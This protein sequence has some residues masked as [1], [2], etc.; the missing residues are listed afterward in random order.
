MSTRMQLLVTAVVAVLAGPASVAAPAQAAYEFNLPTQSL[1]D[2]LRAI[3]RQSALNILFEP[4]VV[5]H[6]VAPPVKGYLSPAEAIQRVLN[7]TQLVVQEAAANSLVIAPARAVKGSESPAA[8]Q[9]S[10]SERFEDA[11]HLL[12]LAQAAPAANSAR[13]DVSSAQTD[14]SEERVGEVLVK[15]TRFYRASDSSMAAKID[16]PILETPQAVSVISNDLIKTFGI[17]DLKWISRYV[18]GLDSRVT[19]VAENSDFTARGFTLDLEDGFKMNGFQY[20]PVQPIDTVA[21]ERIEFLKGPTGILYGRNDYGGMLNYVT[22]QPENRDF[23][24]LTFSAGGGDVDLARAE[25]DTN[26]SLVDNVLMLRVPMAYELHDT[27]SDHHSRQFSAVPSLRWQ[28]S[29]DFGVTLATVLQRWRVNRQIGLSPWAIG[30]SAQEVNW[31]DGNGLRCRDPGI[32]CTTPPSYLRNTFLGSDVDFYDSTM[33]QV[34][35]KADYRINDHLNYFLSGSYLRS[36]VQTQQHY[37]GTM[38]AED[39]SAFLSRDAIDFR[40]RS[41]GV[42][43]GVTGDFGLF[44]RRHKF[45]VGGDYRRYSL[46]EYNNNDETL[47]AEPIDVFAFHDRSDFKDYLDA[48]GLGRDYV[49]YQI[50]LDRQRR[51]WG[52]GAQIVFELADPLTLLV[53]GRY[54]RSRFDDHYFELESGCFRISCVRVGNYDGDSDERARGSI[55]L[56]RA[57]LTWKIVPDRW[58][59]YASY[60]KGFI[61]QSGI[62]RSGGRIGPETGYQIELGV[63]GQLFEDRF[64]ASFAAWQ[65]KRE[66]VVIGDPNNL[67]GD[68]FVVGGL[69]QRNRGVELEATGLITESLNVIVAASKTQGRFDKSSDTFY[70]G[71]EITSTPEYKVSGY[72]NYDFLGPTLHGFSVGS[73]VTTVGPQWGVF[74]AAFRVDRYTTVD[75]KLGYAFNENRRLNLQVQNLLDESYF[76]A[77]GTTWEG[78]CGAFGDGRSYRLSFETRL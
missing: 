21:V 17:T 61:P 44:G 63:K 68:I 73:G 31:Q 64:L 37:I 75:L 51:D 24:D 12:R 70:S 38:I 43:T 4:E 66:G 19:V 33:T 10:V 67:P 35:A 56:P 72:L 57:G 9:T 40:R 25:I 47:G 16:L 62:T 11:P 42:E 58:T 27:Y 28:V 7:G 39:G 49:P 34:N 76:L 69:G 60:T 52:I 3:G 8:R 65:I 46:N 6:L 78:C 50:L 48:N 74:P 18:S 53:G 36:N 32:R 1:A 5:Q 13:P 59:A 55:F 2:A 26:A 77:R 45:Y 20:I 54:E 15:A 14:G 41:R 22:K 71:K 30:A 29:D 23:T